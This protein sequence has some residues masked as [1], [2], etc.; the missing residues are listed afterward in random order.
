MP[1]F[2][3]RQGIHVVEQERK[4]HCPKYL[5]SAFKPSLFR[6]KLPINQTYTVASAPAV[7]GSVFM[8]KIQIILGQCGAKDFPKKMDPHKKEK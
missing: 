1:E 7:T 3:T 6:L 2:P 5:N 8:G 4:M